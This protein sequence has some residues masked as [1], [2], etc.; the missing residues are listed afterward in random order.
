M[1]ICQSTPPKAE[2]TTIIDINPPRSEIPP[3]K[4]GLAQVLLPKPLPRTRDWPAEGQQPHLE[5]P[6]GRRWDAAGWMGCD[7][8]GLGYDFWS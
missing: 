1:Y 4:P 7:T 5:T 6:L 3:T 8:T 2:S